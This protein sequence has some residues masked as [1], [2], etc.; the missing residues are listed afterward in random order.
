MN[1]DNFFLK[2]AT[3]AGSGKYL[4]SNAGLQRSEPPRLGYVRTA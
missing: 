2:F 4:S 1:L 3:T